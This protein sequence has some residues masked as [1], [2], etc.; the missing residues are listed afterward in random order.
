M[1]GTNIEQLNKQTITEKQIEDKFVRIFKNS[2]KPNLI[3]TSGQ[4]IDSWLHISC[5]HKKQ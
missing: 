3:Y 1:E 5:M 4:N 2:N